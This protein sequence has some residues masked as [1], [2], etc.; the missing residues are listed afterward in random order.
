MKKTN[1][2]NTVY[3]GNWMPKKFI[4]IG[5][6]MSIVLIPGV[7]F[8][9]G[10][11]F[12]ILIGIPAL[13]VL[14]MLFSAC[15]AYYYFS[16]EGKNLQGQINNLVA[17]HLNWDGK[18]SCLEIGCAHAYLSILLAKKYP[19]AHIIALDYWGKSAF[20]YTEKQCR[21]NAESEGVA[22]Q[23]EFIFG[24]AASLP[25]KDN[26]IDAVVSNLTFHEVA[27]FKMKEKHKSF[28][29]ALRVLKKGGVFAI[30]DVF[31]S[32]MIYG[33][34]DELMKTLKAEVAELHFYN[35][36]KEAHLP[37]WL[38][39]PIMMGGIGIFYGRK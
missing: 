8:V 10:L 11:L 15:R 36:I 21:I 38:D 17:D 14:Y 37:S 33:D 7:I 3:Y 2:S 34:F 18:G 6:C 19:K 12:R 29:E 30:Q 20:E 28:L 1:T 23:I 27:D 26:S 25:F 32:K 24:S 4:I 22:G 39:N 31:D 16:P 13:F 9:P 35:T 5:I